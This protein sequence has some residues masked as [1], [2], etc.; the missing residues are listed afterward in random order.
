MHVEREEFAARLSEVRAGVRRPEEGLFGPSSETWTI[1]RETLVFLGAGRAALLQ[2]AHPYVA[3]AIA[4][5]SRTRDDPVGRFN[6]T[7]LHVYA[8]LFGDLASALGSAERVRKVHERVEGII[9]PAAGPYPR[10]HVYRANEA[11]ALLWV[12]ATL[13]ETAVLAYEVGFG[14]LPLARKDRVY[15]ELTGFGRLFGIP[16]SLFPKGW[17]A[18]SAYCARTFEALAVTTPAREMG[19]FLLAAPRPAMAPVMGFYRIFTTGFLPPVVRE[20]YGLPYG[21]REERVFARGKELVRR[22]WPHLP[23]RVRFLPDYVEATRRLRG[24]QAPRDRTGRA[25]EQAILW[26]LRPIAKAATRD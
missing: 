19:T 25:L 22:V 20:G 15:A 18:F 13:V 9:D 7:F 21:A 14:H 6:R 1:A 23:E 17:S 2:L 3:H 24:E 11:E 26:A 12:F 8:M 16:E 4:E 10:G 5:H